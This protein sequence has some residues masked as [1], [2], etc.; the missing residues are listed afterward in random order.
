MFRLL[1]ICL[2]P[3]FALAQAGQSFS[4]LSPEDTL[5]FRYKAS[6]DGILSLSLLDKGNISMYPH[7]FKVGFSLGGDTCYS[8]Q[9]IEKKG[10]QQL[11][12][13]DVRKD[14]NVKIWIHLYDAN[15][16]ELQV[17]TGNFYLSFQK[18]RKLKDQLSSPMYHEWE[19]DI[20]RAGVPAS[21]EFNPKKA[22]KWFL[23]IGL[24]PDYV[25]QNLKLNMQV[26]QGRTEEAIELSIPVQS[27]ELDF[28][29]KV[30][31]VPIDTWKGLEDDEITLS[32][33]QL[34]KGF[35][36]YGVDFIALESK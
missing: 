35:V 5:S 9:V 33:N 27:N 31:R 8:Y 36:L 11:L 26:K 21:F 4:Y 13:L 25:Y 23:V 17:D 24:K 14:E 16:K 32:F 1:I 19:S 3:V 34:Q 28:Q 12:N 18:D 29:S 22:E 7:G 20:W 30:L 2:L 15:R 6:A 10:K